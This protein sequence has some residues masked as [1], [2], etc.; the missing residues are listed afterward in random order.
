M[1]FRVKPIDNYFYGFLFAFY[2][3]NDPCLAG[4]NGLVD[5]FIL[6][7]HNTF[8]TPYKLWWIYCKEWNKNKG[9]TWPP[10][11]MSGLFYLLTFVW[12]YNAPLGHF[13]LNS[14]GCC[15]V[16]I[17]VFIWVVENV[18]FN[19]ITTTKFTKLTYI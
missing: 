16:N 1:F 18:K 3:T 14:T 2:T 13:K 9:K 6:K 15:S 5:L 11:V 10:R 19:D 12:N 17:L 7:N 4:Y 8:C